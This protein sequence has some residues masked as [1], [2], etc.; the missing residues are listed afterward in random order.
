MLETILGSI[1]AERVLLFLAAR[2][3]GYA[4]KIARVFDTDL[5]PI[6]N[7]LDRMERGG[8]VKHVKQ[9]RKKVYRL[10]PDYQLASELDA[11]VTAAMESLPASQRHE[12]QSATGDEMA[13]QGVIDI[14]TRSRAEL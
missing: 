14:L 3:E 13:D 2:G 9:G 5:S 8:L 1:S 11:L 4:T 10:D 6:Q 7:Q 12:L